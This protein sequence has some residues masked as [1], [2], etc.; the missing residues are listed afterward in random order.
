MKPLMDVVALHM[1]TAINLYR[2][3]GVT[4]LLPGAAASILV[5]RTRRL[6]QG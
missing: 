4:G 5:S 6:E 1:A 2:L 3:G